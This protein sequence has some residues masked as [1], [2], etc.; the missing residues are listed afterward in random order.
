MPETISV[1]IL[2]AS[3]SEPGEVRMFRALLVAGVIVALFF[4]IKENTGLFGS[5]RAVDA[6]IRSSSEWWVCEPGEF[7][8][9]PDL[10]DRSCTQW[11]RIGDVAYWSCPLEA[12]GRPTGV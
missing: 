4:T 11:A 1:A 5:C 6:P 3:Y 10:S 2:E 8:G 12:Y 7:G 9:S